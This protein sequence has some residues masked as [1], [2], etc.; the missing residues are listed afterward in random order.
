MPVASPMPMEPMPASSKMDPPLAKA[1][2]IT[3]GGSASGI[4]ELRRGKK[5]CATAIA[6]GE[7]SETT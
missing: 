3:D 4:T 6:A 2:A 5:T 1:E 7:R